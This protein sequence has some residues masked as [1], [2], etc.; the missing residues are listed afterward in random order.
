MDDKN[1][2][3]A[4]SQVQQPPAQQPE[5][6][7]VGS[8]VKEHGP[9]SADGLRPSGPEPEIHPELEKIDVKPVPEFPTVGPSEQKVGIRPSGESVPVKTEPIGLAKLPAVEEVKTIIKTT[10]VNYSLRWWAETVKK[11]LKQLG[12]WTE[13]DK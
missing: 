2:T 5:G 3:Q 11:V 1:K 6:G 12:L 8:L 7:S 4:Q 13:K 10:N 9:I